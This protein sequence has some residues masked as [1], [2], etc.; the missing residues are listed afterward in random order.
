VVGACAVSAGALALVIQTPGVSQ[1]FGCRPLGPVGW[2][3]GAAAT[4]L[5]TI[6]GLVVPR[7]LPA[8]AVWARESP[9]S[10]G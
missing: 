6:A 9:M 10:Q 8:S 2:T 5:G 4:T 1:F 7:L 3:T